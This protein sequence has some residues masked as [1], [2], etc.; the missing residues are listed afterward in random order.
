MWSTTKHVFVALLNWIFFF[1]WEREKSRREQNVFLFFFSS[2]YGIELR[3]QNRPLTSQY[4]VLYVLWGHTLDPVRQHLYTPRWLIRVV[5]NFSK[6]SYRTIF[7]RYLSGLAITLD[8]FYRLERFTA[9]SLSSS[10][11]RLFL[12]FFFLYNFCSV[13]NWKA[14]QTFVCKWSTIIAWPTLPF[15][16]N[17]HRNKPFFDLCKWH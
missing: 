13:K 7:S 3:S 15:S 4:S 11:F 5:K 12:T 8:G 9:C 17:G 10:I 6:D 16:V 2:C 14:T 1:F